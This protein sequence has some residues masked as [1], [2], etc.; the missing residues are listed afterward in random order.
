M[1]KL[2]LTLLRS[3]MKKNSHF[4]FVGMLIKSKIVSTEEAPFPSSEGKN[5]TVQSYFINVLG[6]G[7]EEFLPSFPN[8]RGTIT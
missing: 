8:A 5:E 1:R 4:S 6:H 2:R 3:K 7:M